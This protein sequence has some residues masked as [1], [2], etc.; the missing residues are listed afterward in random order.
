MANSQNNWARYDLW[1]ERHLS[2]DRFAEKETA[3]LIEEAALVYERRGIFQRR[4]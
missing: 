4:F 3:S 2:L 1:D